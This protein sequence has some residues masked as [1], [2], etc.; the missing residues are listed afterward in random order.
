M[1]A[2][3]VSSTGDE[4]GVLGICFLLTLAIFRPLVIHWRFC[5]SCS[6]CSCFSST[7]ME[8]AMN[9]SYSLNSI[10]GRMI[11]NNN[12]QPD[13]H[14]PNFYVHTFLIGE[15]QAVADSG[16]YHCFFESVLCHVHPF[17]LL[18]TPLPTVRGE[19]RHSKKY[20]RCSVAPL[21][22]IPR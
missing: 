18:A 17:L 4:Q 9:S 20:Q 14:R 10:L 7:S 6:C 5:F 3:N 8:L 21:C 16:V 22:V 12:G 2:L 1:Y 13:G 15:I 11:M 19:R